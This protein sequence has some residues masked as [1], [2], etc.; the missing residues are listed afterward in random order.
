MG[1]AI[2]SFPGARLL[3]VPRSRFA[4]VKTTDD[5]LL[6]RSDAYTLDDRFQLAPNT[7]PTHPDGRL[8]YVELDPSYY[9]L[10]DDFERR[11]PDGPPSL[12]E[13][14]RLVVH[15]DVTFGAGVVVR[16]AVTIDA[17]APRVIAPGTV[18]DG[19]AQ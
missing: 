17:A 14:E 13:A 3:C 15:G 11:I 8:P 16:G 6:L 12:R 2:G 10:I 5:L 4:P 7:D 1:A 18:L 9:K 19:G